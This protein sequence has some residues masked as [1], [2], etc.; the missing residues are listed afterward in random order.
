[1]IYIDRI[2]YDAM[3]SALL[4][5]PPESG[6]VLGARAGQ[7]ISKFYF[8]KSG[9]SA[10]DSYTPDCIAINAALDEWAKDDI[11][12]VGIAHSHEGVDMTPSCGDLFYSKQILLANPTLDKFILPILSCA[13]QKI[14]VYVCS[15]TDGH[16]D[17]VK[18][19]WEF[20]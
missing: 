1:M 3:C 18:D 8:D 4:R 7:P 12:M 17:V 6:G 2:A 20:V 10:S 14:E 5:V 16:V 15:L 9:M 19:C 11:V 13:A